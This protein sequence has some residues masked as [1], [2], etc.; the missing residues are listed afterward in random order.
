MV[1]EAKTKS[2][3]FNFTEKYQFSTKLSIDD[4]PVEVID[5]T[6]LL[7][8]LITKVGGKYC[9]HCQESKCT[10]GASKQSSQLWCKCGRSE[11]DIFS[12]CNKPTGASAVVWHSSLSEDNKSDLERVQKSALKIILKALVDLEIESLENRREN[13]CLRFVIKCSKNEKNKNIFPLNK[14][15]H[16][17]TTRKHEKFEVQHA[18]TGRLHKSPL[19]FMQ[20]LLSNQENWF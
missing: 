1:N 19:L 4:K 13:L 18:N 2:M 20:N 9:T 5:S 3:I 15:Q 17:M 12:L 8:T 11:T 7:G 14:K 10:H 6:R 16:G